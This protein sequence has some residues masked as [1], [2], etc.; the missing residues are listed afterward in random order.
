MSVPVPWPPAPH[1]TEPAWVRFLL[2]GAALGFLGLFLALPLATIFVEALRRGLGVYAAAITDPEALA[3]I[4]LT[5]MVTAIAVAA[6]SAFGV[7][8]A[9]A[10]T[11]FRFVGRSVLLSL[12]DL[13]FA[14]SP[15]VAGLIFVLL[16]GLQGLFGRWLIDHHLR[17][18]FATPG[19]ILA[20]IFITVPFVA[21]ELIPL[22]EARGV[23][24][25]E[26]AR[27]LGAGGWRTFWTV[28]VPAIR[29]GLLYGVILCSARA[30]GEFGAVSVVSGHIRN[31]TV[32]MP[33]QV[34]ILYDEY[35]FAASFA[36]ASLLSLLSLVTLALKRLLEWRLVSERA[37]DLEP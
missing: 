34:E 28:T 16:F 27:T 32:T 33:L 1:R 31:Q 37:Q 23:E 20:T 30:M 17:V 4:R 6:N 14:V 26:A 25:E 8:A 15:V 5:L 19:I 2:I 22:M 13:P 35:Q 24:E 21:R 9:W 7:C 3:A 11:K 29:W 36:I 12:I 18:I 10:I